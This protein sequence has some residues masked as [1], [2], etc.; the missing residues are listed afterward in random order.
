MGILK[1]ENFKEL[2][3]TDNPKKKT[4]WRHST[5]TE[6]RLALPLK[7]FHIPYILLSPSSSA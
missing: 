4:Q 7:L 5:T 6:E 1:L 3:P 2:L